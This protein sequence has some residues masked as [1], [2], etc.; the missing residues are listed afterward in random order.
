VDLLGNIYGVSVATPH[1]QQCAGDAPEFD[2]TFNT[3]VLISYMEHG[4][5]YTQCIHNI[6]PPKNFITHFLFQT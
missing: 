6:T 3:T 4:P 5:M 2:P 1:N